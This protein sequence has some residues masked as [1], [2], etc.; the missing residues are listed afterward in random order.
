MLPPKP[1]TFINRNAQSIGQRNENEIFEIKSHVQNKYRLWRKSQCLSMCT[2]RRAETSNT[3]SQNCAD[4]ITQVICV[5]GSECKKQPQKHADSLSAAECEHSDIEEL[6]ALIETSS[7]TSKYGSTSRSPS[8][9]LVLRKG[10]SDPFNAH[11]IAITP[12]VNEIMTFVRDFVTPGFYFTD[13]LQECSATKSKQRQLNSTDWVSATAAQQSWQSLVTGLDDRCTALACLSTYLTIMTV[14]KQDASPIFVMIMQL[15]SKSTMLL[16][17]GLESRKEIPQDK[18]DLLRVF[19]HFCA[20]CVVQNKAAA[21]IHGTMLLSLTRQARKRG[22]ISEHFMLQVLFFDTDLAVKTMTRSVFSPEHWMP[23][24][25]QSN[26]S[27]TAPSLPVSVLDCETGLDPCIKTHPLRGI[28]ALNRQ[29]IEICSRPLTFNPSSG[30]DANACFIYVGS[31]SHIGMC[32]LVN[33][34]LDLTDGGTLAR[35]STSSRNLTQGQ[36]Y[37]EAAITL[38]AIYII[39]LIG[40]EVKVNGINIRDASPTILSH[41]HS[42]LDLAL[43]HLTPSEQQHYQGAYL[44]IFYIGAISE[45]LAPMKSDIFARESDYE[46]FRETVSRRFYNRKFAR[47]A[48][49]MGLWSWA[50][51]REVLKGFIYSDNVEPHGSSWLYRTIGA[52]LDDHVGGMTVGCA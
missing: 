44:W 46:V 32:K 35:S 30:L 14:F 5:R 12:F 9:L 11:G 29:L 33:H 2:H 23:S 36:T 51:V 41:L 49:Q 38:S 39:R 26:W 16:R 40:Y 24:F 4:R 8:P 17:R 28:F 13:F 7:S 3:C 45:Q 1:L 10:S 37:T 21:R 25:F 19:W 6:P 22:F 18:T 48:F 31:M 50:E 34:Y 43:K 47:Q 20:E 15:K 42:T 52:Y 27:R